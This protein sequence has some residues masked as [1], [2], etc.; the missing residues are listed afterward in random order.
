[1]IVNISFWIEVHYGNKGLNLSMFIVMLSV[2]KEMMSHKLF[3]NLH[4]LVRSITCLNV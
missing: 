4:E 2:K 1:M 3:H